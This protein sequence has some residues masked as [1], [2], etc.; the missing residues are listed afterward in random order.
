MKANIEIKMRDNQKN[1]IKKYKVRS[2]SRLDPYYQD[3]KSLIEK[4]CSVRSA[5][6]ITN[7]DMKEETISY[8]PFLVYTNKYIKKK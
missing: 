1:N 2:G 4:G 3:I 7:A 8:T 6:K 5:W